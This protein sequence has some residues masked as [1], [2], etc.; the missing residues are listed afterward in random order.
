[1]S[2]TSQ[3]EAQATVANGSGRLIAWIGARFKGSGGKRRPLR[4]RLK[5][6]FGLGRLIGIALLLVLGLVH[7]IDLGPIESIRV[8]AFDF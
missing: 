4:V 5:E 1:M 2:E 7:L 8:T 6:W 3:T